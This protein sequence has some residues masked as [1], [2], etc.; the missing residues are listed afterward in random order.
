[1]GGKTRLNRLTEITN[2]ELELSAIVV[3]RIELLLH[4]KFNDK[5]DLVDDTIEVASKLA[6]L[7]EQIE[8]GDDT[9]TGACGPSHRRAFAEFQ[10]LLEKLT[11]SP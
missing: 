5:L 6:R 3:A 7:I 4:E 11:M 10:Q 2:G 9:Y 8:G 1:M